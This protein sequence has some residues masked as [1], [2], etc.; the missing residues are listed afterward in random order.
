MTQDSTIESIIFGILSPEEIKRM[1]VCQITNTKL[2]GPGSVYDESMGALTDTQN[3]CVTCGLSPRLCPGHF[4]YIEFVEP[5]LH[6]LY[7]K[8][9]VKFLKCFC[10]SCYRLV[11][12]SDQ[13]VLWGLSNSVRSPSGGE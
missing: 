13:L 5:I 6:P 11:I 3:D 4:G 12:H 2:S 10:K 8:I 9:I 7:M 1:A